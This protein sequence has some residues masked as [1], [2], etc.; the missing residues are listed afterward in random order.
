MFTRTA[1]SASLLAAF[2]TSTLAQ[3]PAVAPLPE[4]KSLERVE[5]TGSRIKRI[6]T[7]TSQPVFTL[8]R[9]AIQAQ[10]LSSLGDVLK[11][12]PQAVS[13]MNSG[14]NFG[15][16]GEARLS[17][18]NLGDNRTL[19]LVNGRRWV[20]G[21]GLGGAVDLNTIP[22]AAVERIE[23]LKDGASVIYGSDAIGGVVNIILRKDLEGLELNTYAGAYQQGD[24]ARKAFD[25]TWGAS[26]E[27]WRAM[28][29]LGYV[30][31]S[32]LGAGA[33]SI[34]SEPVAGTG[35]ALGS[36]YTPGGTFAVCN[37]PWDRVNGWCDAGESRPDGRPGT[38][39]Y[40]AGQSGVNWRART[41]ADLYNYTPSQY[42]RTPQ[43]RTSLFGHL[44]FDLTPET[45][46]Q[47][48]GTWNR[49]LS[50]QRFA[51]A[52]VILGTYGDKEAAWVTAIS[53][54]SLYNPFGLDISD[55]R[56]RITEAGPRDRRQ[57]VTTVAVSAQ[58]DGK[59]DWGGRPYG[60]NA[61]ITLGRSRMVQNDTGEF[62]LPALN[63]ALGPSML[64]ASGQPVC[65]ATAGDIG[66][67][68]PGCVPMNLLG[69][70]SVTPDMLRGTL[71]STQARRGYS[72]AMA[73]G[74]LSG[75]LFDLPAGPVR[76]ASGLEYRRESGF[77]RPDARVVAGQVSVGASTPTE[78]G[79][80]VAEAFAELDVP[81]VKDLPA[82]KAVNLSLGGRYSH[83]SNF[84]STTNAKAGLTWRVNDGLLLRGSWSQG[85]RAPSILEL[86]LGRSDAYPRLADPCAS[87]S[88]SQYA[89]LSDAQKAR[90][91]AQGV[92]VGGYAQDG[93]QVLATL[94]GNPGLKP[95][96]SVSKTLGFVASPAAVRGL[97]F[98]VDW[99]SISLRNV[100]G[101][102]SAQ[103]TVDKCIKDGND[104]A[105]KAY[106]RATGGSLDSL[107]SG[108][109]NFASVDASGI[110]FGLNYRFP[111]S[112]YGQFALA[113]DSTLLRRYEWDRDG[114]NRVGTYSTVD[115]NQWRL[116]SNAALRWSRGLWGAH[117]GLRYFSAQTEACTLPSSYKNLCSDPEGNK[118]VL[119]A[120]VYHDVSAW[121]RTP[122]NGRITFG[123][124]NL[125]GRNPPTAY[126]A[127][128]NSFD[129]AYDIPGRFFYL[130]Y[131]QRF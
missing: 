88:D 36:P 102:L 126:S 89:S 112:S 10:G 27:R 59:V 78:G 110:D 13:T 61:G 118:N 119:G 8:S 104:E 122:W 117:W 72:L 96:T 128:A 31:E 131:S 49:R 74:G 93:A 32:A 80:N 23:V 73:Y 2:A 83:Y 98:S 51:A 66:S 52:P 22:T 106:T 82:A 94:G 130:R 5:V 81:L 109:A 100:I 39:T 9:E 11:N 56:R 54:D 65:V 21:T 70:G 28:A 26:G 24:G 111:R 19:V 16:N 30:N 33:R 76:F 77:D 55:I 53:K 115:G 69:P 116:R 15:G 63:A 37:G 121:W 127:D 40:D 113:W 75:S 107:Y 20:G 43:E 87:N 44:A 1:L 86:Y 101:A 14:V 3:S 85:F 108:A 25:L 124:N 12:L 62:S 90:C 71:L 58:L 79:F 29:G 97:D 18:R 6:D 105:C 92:P 42:L 35:T 64:D 68:I 38:F 84:G 99:W 4:I 91:H 48:Q 67:V 45:Q 57:D 123:V 120:T 41:D 47:L 129:A 46:L 50:S 34:S 7:E 103:E 95:E 114:I 17:L 125:L 60:W